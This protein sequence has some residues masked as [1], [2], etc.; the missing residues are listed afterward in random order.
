M[1]LLCWISEAAAERC[2][3]FGVIVELVAARLV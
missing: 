1:D 2:A 3:S